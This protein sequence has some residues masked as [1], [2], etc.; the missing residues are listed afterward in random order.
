[1]KAALL[2][3]DHVA[4][5]LVDVHGNYPDMYRRLLEVPFNSYYVC[6]DD[7]PSINQ[8][9]LFICS[10]SKFSV[11]DDLEWIQKLKEFTRE[12]YKEGKKF[13]GICF[14]HQMIA[15]ALGGKVQ[16][17]EH[18]YLI[19]LHQFKITG[20][21]AWM[22]PYE[23][24]VRMLMLCQ[25]QVFR[26]P[27]GAEL[28]ASSESCNIGMFAA[29][30]HFLGIQGHPD[31]TPAYNRAVFESRLKN[32]PFKILDKAVNSLNSSPDN[33]K[34]AGYIHQFITA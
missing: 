4:D 34:I 2:V 31:F 27:D 18:G 13:I 15:E 22:K 26:M 11:Y 32:L 14:G 10:G 17:S 9:D 28:L 24:T 25:D 8:Y 29:G 16:R 33:E 6:D 20:K 21:K 1:M 3:C 7:F 12:V 23:P 5:E 19:G 30:N